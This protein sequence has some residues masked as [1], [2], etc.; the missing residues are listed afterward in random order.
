MKVNY[1][2]VINSL[3]QYQLKN[4]HSHPQNHKGKEASSEE[5]E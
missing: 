4:A 1:S 3:M 5:H 2:D